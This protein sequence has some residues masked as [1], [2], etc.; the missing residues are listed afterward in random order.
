MPHPP[1]RE[2]VLP[3]LLCTY[4][5]TLFTQSVMHPEL[6]GLA[7]MR[8]PR[9]EYISESAAAT[10]TAAAACLILKTN[11]LF[12]PRILDRSPPRRFD[13]RFARTLRQR[14]ETE[15]QESG[16]EGDTL[17]QPPPPLLPP[18]VCCVCEVFLLRGK[19]ERH[20]SPKCA[21]RD[22][23]R[24]GGVTRD[25]QRPQVSC[26]SRGS[27]PIGSQAG[28]FILP[29]LVVNNSSQRCHVSALISRSERPVWPLA[30][31]DKT[32]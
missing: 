17:A 11:I 4:S 3:M 16:L 30:Q 14:N 27:P 21:G 19:V 32:L 18:T 29:T 5:P 25:L 8:R 2:H 10:A 1:E 6:Y 31:L 12:Q 9:R 15:E 24:A 22:N 26:L 20:A 28:A 13:L 23:C 7:G